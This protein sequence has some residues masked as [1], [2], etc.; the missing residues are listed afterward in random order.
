[1]GVAH[2]HPD[3]EYL[4]TSGGGVFTS[5]VVEEEDLK[6]IQ[7]F[8]GGAS[9]AR[10]AEDVVFLPE[11]G[12]YVRAPYEPRG[13]LVVHDD[14][15]HEEL[16]VIELPLRTASKYLGESMGN[17]YAVSVLEGQARVDIVDFVT[18]AEPPLFLRGDPNASGAMDISDAVSI[19]RYAYVGM[20][21]SVRCEDAGDTD[22]DG[23][24][25]LSDAVRIINY[26][27]LGGPPPEPP[28]GDGPADCAWD[29][30]RDTLGCELYFPCM[31]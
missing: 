4:I 12:M 5:S 3:G 25:D 8:R 30:S 9:G 13:M 19:L 1:M 22:D 7:D 21:E 29:D 6:F 17:V 20:P 11:K 2:F 31:R 23:K 28:W 10:G 24:I 15:S 26:L 16:D 18:F 14:W 27:F